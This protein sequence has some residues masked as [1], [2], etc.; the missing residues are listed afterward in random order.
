LV[1]ESELSPEEFY[2][3]KIF[4]YKGQLE[5][6]YYDNKSFVVDLLILF[7][8]GVK[9][10]A[11]SSNFEFKIFPSLPKNEFFQH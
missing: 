2:K 7:L 9:I 5:K 10:I 1:T 4:P 8:T 6:W 3:K 11:P